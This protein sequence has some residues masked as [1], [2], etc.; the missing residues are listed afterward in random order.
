MTDLVVHK[1]PSVGGVATVENDGMRLLGEMGTVAAAG[2]GGH[3]VD[4]S[5]GQTRANGTFPA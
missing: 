4:V 5:E 2:T 3:L 1:T